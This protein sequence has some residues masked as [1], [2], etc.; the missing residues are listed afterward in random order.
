MKQCKLILFSNFYCAL[1]CLNLFFITNILHVFMYVFMYVFIYV[2][3]YVSMYVC[4]YV[5]TYV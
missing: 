2:F 1:S 4:M 5:C 3:M